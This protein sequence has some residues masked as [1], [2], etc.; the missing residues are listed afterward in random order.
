MVFNIVDADGM[1]Q[2]DHIDEALLHACRIGQIIKAS[3]FRFSNITEIT[4]PQQK[5][6]PN[7][8]KSN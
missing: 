8:V 7:K 3:K 5:W 2:S 1:F 6:K 4:W